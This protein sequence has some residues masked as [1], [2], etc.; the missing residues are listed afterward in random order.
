MDVSKYADNL[1]EEIST[2][3][4]VYFNWSWKS[5]LLNTDGKDSW[6]DNLIT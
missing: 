6:E 5:L 1:L 4:F 2:Y 3:A